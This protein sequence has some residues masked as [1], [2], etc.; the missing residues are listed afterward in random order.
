MLGDGG[1]QDPV[2][3]ATVWRG[4]GVHAGG[5]AEE[6]ERGHEGGDAAAVGSVGPAPHEHCRAAQTVQLSECQADGAPVPHQYGRHS[7][8]GAGAAGGSQLELEVAGGGAVCRT[9]GAAAGRGEPAELPDDSAAA[10]A[11]A[12][13]TLDNVAIGRFL[14]IP[15]STNQHM[16]YA[17]LC[18]L[19]H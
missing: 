5:G 9:T 6:D 1:L 11:A 3:A 2:R 10:A 14:G 4:A 8:G 13:H 15:N 18:H 12:Q 16:Q 7:G 17:K 19:S